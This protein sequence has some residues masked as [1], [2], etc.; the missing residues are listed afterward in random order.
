VKL[1][2]KDIVVVHRSD[3]SGTT[4]ISRIASC[5]S[6]EWKDTVGKGTSVK[7]PVGLGGKGNEG[8]YGTVSQTDDSIGY[9]EL[10]YALQNKATINTVQNKAGEYVAPSIESTQAAMSDFGTA[11]GDLR[12]LHRRWAGQK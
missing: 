4:F 1:S 9:V 6:P 8:V 7:W 5:V 2:N 10:A 12:P 3:G 11:L